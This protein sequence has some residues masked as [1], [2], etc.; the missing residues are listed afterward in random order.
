[1]KLHKTKLAL[2][3]S[4]I[5]A[6]NVYAQNLPNVIVTA[7]PDV[8]E[9]EIDK[10]SSVSA[11]I[12]DDTIRDLHAADLA[13]ALRNTPGTQIS[14]YN[15]VGSFGGDEGGSIFI[16]GMGLSRPG[17]E[18]KTYIELLTSAKSA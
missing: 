15:P 16:R 5:M 9:I 14:R 13:S 12:T 11:V 17:S 1:M 3:A 2:A 4:L 7:K 18:I 6:G 10:F 8:A